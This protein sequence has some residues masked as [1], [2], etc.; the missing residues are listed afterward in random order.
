M[1]WDV[2][3]HYTHILILSEFSVRTKWHTRPMTGKALS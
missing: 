2:A 3:D 1:A